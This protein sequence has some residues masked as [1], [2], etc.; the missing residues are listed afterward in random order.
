MFGR[1]NVRA[2]LWAR[3]LS[4]VPAAALM[5]LPPYAASASQESP[6][7]QQNMWNFWGWSFAALIVVALIFFRTVGMARAENRN[8]DG[9]MEARALAQALAGQE[10][11]VVVDVREPDEFTG[12]LGHIKGAINAPLRGLTASP[13]QLA[14]Y[15][16]KRIA[17]ICRTDRR[18]SVAA[19]SL[20]SAGYKNVI[21]VRGGMTRWNAD[22]LPVV[23]G[24]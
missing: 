6:A 1:Y 22:G 7:I 23:R 20:R 18:A 2:R 4:F 9:W 15:K 11:P 24:R 17:V 10:S 3:R 13:N 16:D 19:F 12:P 5:S 21:V 8:A 14:S